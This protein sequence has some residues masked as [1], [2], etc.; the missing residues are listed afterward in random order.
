[1]AEIQ[2]QINELVTPAAAPAQEPVSTEK[3]DEEE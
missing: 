2:K 1:M 3:E